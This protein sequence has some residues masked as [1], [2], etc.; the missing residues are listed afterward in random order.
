MG[1]VNPITAQISPRHGG[2]HRFTERRPITVF[3]VLGIGLA[4]TLAMV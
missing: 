2:L 4:Y 1:Q 3:L